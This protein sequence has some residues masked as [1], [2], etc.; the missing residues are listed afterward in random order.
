MDYVLR[1]VV[2][3][4]VVY[5]K[6]KE[7]IKEIEKKKYFMDVTDAVQWQQNVRWL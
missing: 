6:W 5:D 1:R 2:I 4:E 3:Q 7:Y